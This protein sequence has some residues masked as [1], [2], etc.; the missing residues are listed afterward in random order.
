MRYSRQETD[1]TWYGAVGYRLLDQPVSTRLTG[2]LSGTWYQPDS[3]ISVMAYRERKDDSLLSQTGTWENDP[4]RGDEQAW[5]GVLQTGLRALGVWTIKP[6]WA[7]AISTDAAV[8]DGERVDDNTMYAVRADLNYDIAS[9]VWQKMDYFRVGPYISWQSYQ[10]DLSAFTVGHGGYFS[11][12]QFLSLGGAAE[13]LTL[14]AEKWQVRAR[15]GVGWSHIKQEGNVRFP[16]LS[17]GSNIPAFTQ[18]GFNA[19]MMIE[20]QYQ[21]SKHWSVAA[22]FSRA[23]AVAYQA[24]YAGIEVRWYANNRSGVTSDML[25]GSNPAL[26]GYAF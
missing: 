22:Y 23:H 5:G 10:H 25:I 13:F 15:G 1:W 16:L 8:L 19:E 14:E 7:V 26:K 17:T 21:L 11:P 20:G 3:L 6:D 2:V 24:S 18:R 12:Q 9:H 4:D